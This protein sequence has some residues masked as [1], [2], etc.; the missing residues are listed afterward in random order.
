MKG[1][2]RLMVLMGENMKCEKGEGIKVE[3]ATAPA[4]RSSESQAKSVAKHL[5]TTLVY[6]RHL[7]DVMQPLD[8]DKFQLAFTISSF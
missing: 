7:I 8:N 6:R 1:V 4:A 2:N 5:M 3:S